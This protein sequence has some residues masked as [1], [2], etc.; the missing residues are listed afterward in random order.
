MLLGLSSSTRG[1]DVNYDA[2]ASGNGEIGV[3]HENELVAFARSAASWDSDPAAI[4]Q[5]RQNLVD[6][7]G[8]EG[9]A[10]A[11]MVVGNFTMM[12]RIA[13]ST[14]TP[15]DEFSAQLSGDMRDTL[16]LN[17]LT[18]ARLMS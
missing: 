2:M 11:A 7:M 5:A 1:S 14:G 6:V 13:D 12:T 10:E 3:A 8:P 4:V 15:L 16:G 18:S 9:M 17:N